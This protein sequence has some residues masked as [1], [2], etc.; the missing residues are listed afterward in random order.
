MAEALSQ[1]RGRLQFLLL[2]TLFCAPLI[3]AYSLHFG[4]PSQRPTS[5][6]NYGVLENPAR[7]LP[8][9]LL[10]QTDGT[11]VDET[12]FRGRWTLVQ[13]AGGS[14][15]SD[16]RARLVLSR[17]TRTAM[18]EKRDRVARV[19]IAADA[20]SASALRAELSTEQPDLDVLVE[21]VGQEALSSFLGGA[22]PGTL[23]LIDPLG[24]W[25]MSYPAGQPIEEEFK[26]LQ[27]D[28]KKLLRLSKIG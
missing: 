7:P 1:S 13:F 20:A 25:L 2:A 27:K 17:Q 28:L 23:Y 9:L 6:T 24:N 18:H 5:T 14:C 8:A 3:G 4:F 22:V 10:E 26:G 15:E 21:P 16:C 12:Q 11:G 19:L